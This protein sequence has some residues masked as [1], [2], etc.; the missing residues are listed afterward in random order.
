[1]RILLLIFA[2]VSF[3]TLKAQTIMPLSVANYGPA[4]QFTQHNNL[5]G[6]SINA[7][8]K[9]FT[10]TY[11]GMA[12]GIGFSGAGNTSFLSVPVG[13]QLNR[14]L[15]NNLYAF[16]AIAVAPAYFNFNRPLPGT[17]NNYH[18]FNGNSFGMQSSISAGLMYVNDAKTFSISGS[19]GIGRNDYP[20]YQPARANAKQPLLTGSRQ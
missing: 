8:K 10:S 18:S 11:I 17:N 13:I 16:G 5:V 15:N 2:S 20:F 12:T 7:H 14:R 4:D 1:M 6:D 9:W 19:I 3:V